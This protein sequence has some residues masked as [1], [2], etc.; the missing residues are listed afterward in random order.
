MSVNC[1][2]SGDNTLAK[3]GSDDAGR[4]GSAA[5]RGGSVRDRNELARTIGEMLPV[6]A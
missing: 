2:V 4:R 3:T 5:Q 6:P 1:G